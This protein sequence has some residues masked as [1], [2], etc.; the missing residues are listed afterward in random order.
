LWWTK[1][2][3]GRILSRKFSK[4]RPIIIPAMFHVLLSCGSDILGLFNV[5]V[6]MDSDL[7]HKKKPTE[8]EEISSFRIRGRVSSTH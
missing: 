4:I 5:A 7:Q 1:L 8:K 6:P 3:Y 2:Q